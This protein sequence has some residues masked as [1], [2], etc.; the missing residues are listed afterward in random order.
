LNPRFTQRAPEEVLDEILYWATEHGVRDFVF[1]DDALL[2]SPD[3][4]IIPLLEGVVRAGA[5]ARFHTPNAVHA[6]DMT[7]EIA[8]L[9]RRAGFETL[10]L[11]FEVL[12]ASRESGL[13]VKVTEGEFVRAVRHLR[14]A[15]FRGGQVGAYVLMGL[16][17]QRPES[18]ADA[19]RFVAEAGAVPYLSEYSP[20]PHTP[21]WAEALGASQYDLKEEPL[22][23][24]NTLI[25]CWDEKKRGEVPRLKGLALEFRRRASRP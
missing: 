23:H 24:N 8:A 12:D 15:G 13:D 21:L 9:M 20:I 11:G 1:Y 5:R 19:V 14:S 10:R 3:S 22:F 18:V 25:P 17:G 4:R 2:I 16:P 7:Q 6:R